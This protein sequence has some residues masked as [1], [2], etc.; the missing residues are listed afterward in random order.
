ER[1]REA[2]RRGDELMAVKNFP[3][4][5][6]LYGQTIASARAGKMARDRGEQQA[7]Q[8]EV[9]FR[10]TFSALASQVPAANSR[11]D[12]ARTLAIQKFQQGEQA[13]Q[14]RQFGTARRMFLDAEGFLKRVIRA[15]PGVTD[16]CDGARANLDR[17]QGFQRRAEQTMAESEFEVVKGLVVKSRSL[18][19]DAKRLFDSN[20][21]D[22]SLRTSRLAENALKRAAEMA[23]QSRR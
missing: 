13:L 15:A 10:S 17:V 7:K 20:Q 9:Q 4:A 19:D 1:A 12:K 6:A 11:E 8:A 22:E 5:V 18:L 21:C 14:A 16:D 2:L 23:L 3:G